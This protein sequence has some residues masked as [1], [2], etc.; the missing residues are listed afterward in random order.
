LRV[1]RALEEANKA[2]GGEVRETAGEGELA[3]W[4]VLTALCAIAVFTALRDW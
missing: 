1:R 4:L 2:F 3:E